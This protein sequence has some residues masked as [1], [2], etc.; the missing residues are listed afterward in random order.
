MP[1]NN[2][3]PMPDEPP[4]VPGFQIP[5]D[6]PTPG[7]PLPAPTFQQN[8]STQLQQHHKK[9][10]TVAPVE[11][12]RKF[13]KDVPPNPVVEAE[14]VQQPCEVKQEPALDCDSKY[15]KLKIYTI[16]E[17]LNY[18]KE[19]LKE[20]FNKKHN[21]SDLKSFWVLFEKWIKI[22]ILEKGVGKLY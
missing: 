5:P 4:P 13:R 14:V 16:D 11:S 3:P 8:G 20:L 17:A 22:H 19:I 18:C 1:G 7:A 2:I 6:A 21:V 9:T 15:D 12:N 10:A